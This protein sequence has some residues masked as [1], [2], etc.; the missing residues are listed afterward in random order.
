MQIITNKHK[1][2][3]EYIYV[4]IWHGKLCVFTA[5]GLMILTGEFLNE[6]SNAENIQ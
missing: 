3:K 1:I 5:E 4:T 6:K 2:S